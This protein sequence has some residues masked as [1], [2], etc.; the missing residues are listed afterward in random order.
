MTPYHPIYHRAPNKFLRY[1]NR[2][3]DDGAGHTATMRIAIFKDKSGAEQE[4]TAQVIWDDELPPT[5]QGNL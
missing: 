3:F 4:M 2:R 5:K 1:E